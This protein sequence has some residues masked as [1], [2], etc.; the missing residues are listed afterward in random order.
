[1]YG[2]AGVFIIFWIKWQ[3]QPYNYPS[4]YD[5]YV[6]F[7]GSVVFMGC[8][9]FLVGVAALLILIGQAARKLL[10]AALNLDNLQT[11]RKQKEFTM[12]G[13]TVLLVLIGLGILSLPLFGQYLQAYRKI[14]CVHLLTV[15][16]YSVV[17][18]SHGT[19]K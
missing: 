3:T 7:V 11:K 9:F 13:G 18:I 17:P 6:S 16:D 12:V 2:L 1:M 14:C 5:D 15:L 10:V 4:F 19:T 8:L